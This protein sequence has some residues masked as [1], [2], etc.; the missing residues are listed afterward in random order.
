VGCQA[1]DVWH[2]S[3]PRSSRRPPARAKRTRASAR[4]LT[5]SG[6]TVSQMSERVGSPTGSGADRSRSPVTVTKRFT[7]RPIV[8]DGLCLRR[9]SNQ[10]DEGKKFYLH[11]AFTSSRMRLS[12]P[13]GSWTQQLAR[14]CISRR[15]VCS[16][17]RSRPLRE[18]PRGS[19]RALH[20]D[21]PI[22]NR[23]HAMC[24]DPAAHRRQRPL[25]PR[26]RRAAGPIHRT[27]HCRPSRARF[28]TCP[29]NLLGRGRRPTP[30]TCSWTDSQS[31]CDTSSRHRLD[32]TPGASQPSGHAVQRDSLH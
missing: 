2:H 1:S 27:D 16:R 14:R 10:G 30:R 15:D 21:P 20:C 17:S 13:G 19:R 4:P 3:E 9:I 25:A 6:A 8:T 18:L 22:C 23:R 12:A 28:A 11:R 24:G 32:G 31:T 7:S 29:G 26:H 5:T